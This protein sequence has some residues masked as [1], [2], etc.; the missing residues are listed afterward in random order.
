MTPLTIR[1]AGIEDLDDVAPLFD[2]YR[3]FYRK[4]PDLAL[5]RKF[6]SER[7]ARREST[8]LLATRPEGRA[9]GFVQLYPSFSSGAAAPILILNDLYVVPEVRRNGVAT[10]LLRAAANVGKAAGAV[11]LKLSTEVTNANAQALYRAEGWQLDTDFCS[12]TLRLPD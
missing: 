1:E 9:V 8:I 6:L 5:A 3:Q 11:W 4:A 12:Y 10:Q 2:A 7:I